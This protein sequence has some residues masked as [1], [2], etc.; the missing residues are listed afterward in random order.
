MGVNAQIDSNS[1]GNDG[2]GFAIPS[3]TVRS[4]VAQLLASGKAQHALLGVDVQTITQQVAAGL[5][6]PAGVEIETVQSGSAADG[7]GL[8]GSTGHKSVG[9]QSYPTGGDVITAAGGTIVTTA[10][11]LRGLIAAKKPGDS[12]EL[13]IERGG[14]TKHV[15][16]TLGSRSA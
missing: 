12:I 3:N 1:G 5:G 4:V 2:V 6:I 16:V 8:R 9:G 13:T 14:N 11:Q 10:E 7:A 15:T